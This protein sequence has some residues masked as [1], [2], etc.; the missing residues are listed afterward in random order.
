MR[1]KKEIAIL[2]IL[3]ILVLC[4][5]CDAHG[6][7]VNPLSGVSLKT[8]TAMQPNPIKLAD[9]YAIPTTGVNVTENTTPTPVSTYKF[10][11]V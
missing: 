10:Q 1:W 9:P 3:S 5:G 11:Y 7:M 8:Q 6:N 4:M 2:I